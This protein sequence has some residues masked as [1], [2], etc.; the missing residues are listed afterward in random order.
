MDGDAAVL[1][2][3]EQ[4]KKKQAKARTRQEAR[5]A[6]LTQTVR[7]VVPEPSGKP[8][9]RPAERPR[10]QA[11]RPRGVT[12]ARTVEVEPEEAQPQQAPT[13]QITR[14]DALKVL[15]ERANAGNQ[16]CLEGLRQ[17]LADNPEIWQQVGDLARHCEFAWTDLIAGNDQL[18]LESIK[19]SI[20]RLKNELAGP[21][22]PPI[23]RL[24]VEQVVITWLASRYAEMAAAEPGPLSLGEARIKLKRAESAQRRHLASIKV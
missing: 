8:A 9:S 12:H 10:P 14:S 20:G 2:A 4:T 24:L 23:E 17:L 5:P 13:R 1:I 3:P 6:K 22:P 19:H 21:N 18:M 7:R 15:V 11:A 16:Y